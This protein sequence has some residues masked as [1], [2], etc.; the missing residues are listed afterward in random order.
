VNIQRYTYAEAYGGGCKRDRNYI[1]ASTEWK[2]VPLGTT[3]EHAIGQSESRSVSSS[4][5][6]ERRTFGRQPRSSRHKLRSVVFLA[7]ARVCW[8]DQNSR[9][10]RRLEDLLAPLDNA[11]P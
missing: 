10:W 7:A 4:V 9:L 8:Y 11:W 6:R 5:K 1:S 2:W 3:K